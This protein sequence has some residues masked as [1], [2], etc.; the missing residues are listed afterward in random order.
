MS[1]LRSVKHFCISLAVSDLILFI[2]GTSIEILNF[3]DFLSNPSEILSFIDSLCTPS[4][5]L[6]VTLPSELDIKK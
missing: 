1:V 3:I 2:S 5:K 4:S 6:D